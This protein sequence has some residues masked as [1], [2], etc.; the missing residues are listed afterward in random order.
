LRWKERKINIS[1]SVFLLCKN[2]APSSEGAFVLIVIFNFALRSIVL[3]LMVIFQNQITYKHKFIPL[4]LK[5]FE[6]CRQGFGG[7]VGIVVKQHNRTV[8]N[9][10]CHPVC[11]ALR[12]GIILPVKRVKARW[13]SFTNG[14]AYISLL[15]FRFFLL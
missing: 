8:F 12:R 11:N 2:P 7:V 15:I 6:Y 9:P 4:F 14:L 3:Y 10:F 13:Y 1:P 5:G